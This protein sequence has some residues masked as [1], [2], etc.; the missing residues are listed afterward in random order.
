ME[1]QDLLTPHV[2]QCPPISVFLPNRPLSA[3]QVTSLGQYSEQMSCE[4]LRSVLRALLPCVGGGGHRLYWV[5]QRN[6][7]GPLSAQV[8]GDHVSKK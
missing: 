1:P 8:P 3:I 6:G 4:K 5:V 7:V 2:P